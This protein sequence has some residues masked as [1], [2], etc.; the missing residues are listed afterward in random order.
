[1]TDGMDLTSMIL[2]PELHNFMPADIACQEVV[3]PIRLQGDTLVV[4]LENP[5][6]EQTLDRLRFMLNRQIHAV[7]VPAT[8]LRYAIWRFY[9]T[10]I[11]N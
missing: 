8:Q 2:P 3:F 5:F 11:R 6:D 1:M 10:R 4:A 9:W 7:G